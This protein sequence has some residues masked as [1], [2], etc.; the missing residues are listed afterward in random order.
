[1]PA[2]RRAAPV[3]LDSPAK[4]AVLAPAKKPYFVAAGT[5]RDGA[6]LGYR[7]RSSG[8][9]AWVA[10][11]KVGNRW[12]EAVVGTADD[13]GAPPGALGFA[14][15]R[16]KA[17]D[18]CQAQRSVG[19]AP[20]GTEPLTVAA[21]AGD[22]LAALDAAARQ[23]GAGRDG[24]DARSVLVKHLLGGGRAKHLPAPLAAKRLDRL[25]RMDLRGWLGGLDTSLSAQSVARLV[26]ALR[27]ILRGAWARAGH[28]APLGWEGL[29][30]EGLNTKAAKRPTAA[31]ARQV[32]D[33]RPD[34]L[35]DGDVVRLLDACRA[36]DADLHRL[37]LVLAATG[38]RFSQVV[39][40]R[41]R[42]LDP[43]ALVLAAPTSAKGDSLVKETSNKPAFVRC[44]V[45]A[46]VLDALRPV[47]DGRAGDALLLMRQRKRQVPG[48][49]EAG[50]GE[51][52]TAASGRPV[53]V[54]E[55]VGEAAPWTDT[56]EMARA[57]KA[58][59]RRA[60][61]PEG[62]ST[63]HLRDWSIIRLLKLGLDPVTV[64]RRHDTSV[65]MIE[66]SYGRHILSA[67]EAALREAVPALVA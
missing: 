60:A 62:I 39:R 5:A 8:A 56:A 49:M 59:L 7:R 45:S 9:G 2:P 34:L 54:G 18:W 24:R 35:A 50:R 52:R 12:R 25:T 22:Y 67:R 33:V 11:L 61:L 42:D 23:R 20:P 66:R 65:A 40:L 21:V 19:S 14:A 26:T 16:A 1:M 4:R 10:R 37:A 41:V 48:G 32:E 3:R 55:R 38:L 28:P 58:A 64:A 43:V 53:W 29:V 47:L 17:L 57:W 46:A 6:S 63:Y 51:W 30:R 13:A 31:A 27:A 15:A 36:V 44:A